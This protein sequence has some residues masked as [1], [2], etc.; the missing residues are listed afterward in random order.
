MTRATAGSRGV[1]LRR[2][3][4]ATGGEVDLDDESSRAVLAQWYAPPTDRWLRLNFV[5]SVD[6]RVAGADGT[7]DSLTNRVD[8]A[9][10]GVIRRTADAVLVGANSV[11]AEGYRMPAHAT[12][13]VATMSGRLDGHDLSDGSRR[14][15]RLLVLAPPGARAAVERSLGGIR[16]ELET[17]GTDD[18]PIT[19]RELLGALRSRGFE[20]VVCEGGPRLATQLLDDG[21]VDELCLT[22]S[23][24]LGG[25]AGGILRTGVHHGR[26]ALSQLLVDDSGAL[27]ARWTLPDR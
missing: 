23:P 22:T 8:R 6:G 10:L 11:R 18:A 26:L 17:L 13:A 21:V 25:S 15:G 19:P 7:S 27:Y 20:S 4:P 24:Q 16:Y 1:R 5:A 9:V 12:L 3:L 14:G 2:L